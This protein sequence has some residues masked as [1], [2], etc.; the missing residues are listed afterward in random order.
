MNRAYGHL[1]PRY[2]P[3]ISPLSMFYTI[4]RPISVKGIS[5]RLVPVICFV[6]LTLL[7]AACDSSNAGDIE[8]PVGTA[9]CTVSDPPQ[10]NACDLPQD[11]IFFG[12]SGRDCIP[13]LT[14]P[15]L[16]EMNQVSYL[17]DRDRVIGLMLDGNPV[18]IP[19]NILWW[20]EIINYDGNS[21]QIAVTYCP[22]T[23]SSIV[24]DRAAIGG[25]ELG[26]SGLLY[27]NNLIMYDRNETEALWSQMLTGARCNSSKGVTLAT[28]SHVEMTWGG[29]KELHPATQVISG[30]TGFNRNYRQYPYDDYE[31]ESN[32]DLLFPM[33]NLDCRR[34]PKERVLGIPGEDGAALTFPFGMLDERGAK[35]V[36]K[37]NFE[38]QDIL[39]LWDREKRSAVAFRPETAGGVAVDIM[40][41]NEAFVDVTTNSV[42]QLD[43]L[44]VE[45][46]LAG[47][48]LQS[49]DEAY[50]A[51]W[52]AWP[53]FH[54][55]T[56]IF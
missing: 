34:P 45:G 55:N 6:L 3:Y 5:P 27:Q 53:A 49:I 23:G 24:F 15:A 51:F 30:N 47:R 35:A 18:A 43:G 52:F 7:L 48:S 42:F 17:D 14:D 1:P 31:I 12:C 56:M 54:P 19:H 11:Q 2:V 16:V 41:Q 22:L 36:V 20:H 32:S 50:V 4:N 8:G 9:E 38:G 37:T 39:V 40:V 21:D 29:W 25:A 26:V 46:D 13:S 10:I 33:D 28:I 44:A